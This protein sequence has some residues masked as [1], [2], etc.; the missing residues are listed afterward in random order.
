MQLRRWSHLLPD[1]DFLLEC[2][3]GIRGLGRHFGDAGAAING[4]RHVQ[5]PGRLPVRQS[6]ERSLLA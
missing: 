3:G 1:E 5:R 6:G 4:A 2:A